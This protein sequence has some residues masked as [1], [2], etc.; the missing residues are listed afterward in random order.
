LGE[1]SKAADWWIVE[2]SVGSLDRGPELVGFEAWVM[3]YSGDAR[4]ALRFE[5]AG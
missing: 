4:V 3:G 1:G 2:R 5:N